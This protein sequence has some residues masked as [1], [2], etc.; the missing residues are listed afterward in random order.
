MRSFRILASIKLAAARSAIAFSVTSIT[1]GSLGWMSRLAEAQT[2]PVAPLIAGPVNEAERVTLSGNVHPLA[3]AKYD[4]GRVEDSFAAGRLYLILKRPNQQEQ[5]LEQFLRDA[6]TAGTASYHQWLTPDAF[7]ARFGPADSDI[8]A[9][10]A[11]L[12]S[13]G[14]TVNKVHPGKMAIEFSGSMA[15]LTAAFHTEIH[16]YGIAGATQYANAS[17]PQIPAAL[18]AVVS[19][20]SP[21]NSFHGQPMIKVQG[22]TNYNKTTHVA[23]PEWTYP[24]GN[25]QEVFELAPADFAVQYDLGPVYA[26]GMTGTGQSIGIL[27]ASNVDLSLV[28][29]YQSLFSLPANLPTVVV[30]GI[31]P[32]Q[33]NAA[34]EAYLD[35]EQA[36]AIAPG[37]KVILYT[38]AGTVLTDPLL[39]SAL[40]AL[41]DNQVSVISMS[42]GVCEAA[43][44]ASGNAAWSALW[45]EAAAQGITG[46]V[47]AGDGGAAGCDNFDTEEFAEAGLA[48]NGYGSTPYNVSVGG[49]DFYF[50]DYAMG[51]SAL[52]AQIWSYWN[53]T[54]SAQPATSLLKPAPEQVWNTSFGL[55][56]NDAGVYNPND[57]SIVS[58]G[59]GAS[60]AAFYPLSG[61]VTGYPKPLWQTGSGVPSDHVRDLPDIALFAGSGSN[62]V[63]YPICASPGDCLNT[64][65]AGA[66]YVTSVGGTSAASPSMAAIQ[67]LVD[68]AT[69]SRQGQAD[70][71]YYAL[72]GKAGAAAAFRDIKVGGNEVP[73]YAGTS[74]CAL[75]TSGSS[76]GWFAESGYSAGVGYDQ[77]SGLGTVDVA[78][79]IQEWTT[80]ALKP[81]TTTLS[82][83][84]ATFAHG[85]KVTMKATVSPESGS[86]TP[87][88]N[89]GLTSN[90]SAA[91][92]NALGVFTLASGGVSSPVDNLPGG[93]YQVMANYSGDGT[94]AAS[95]STPVTVMVSPESDTLN[96]SGWV[97]NPLDNFLYPLVAG[98]S[99]PYGSEVYL[100]A[101]PVGVNEANSTLAQ[102]APATG[103]VTFSDKVGTAT[104]T[105][106][107]ALNSV[108]VAEWT[109]A[110]LAVGGHT[111]S[112]AYP[113]D[114]SYA[115]SSAA[116]AATLTV[117]KGTTT[118]FVDPLETNVTAGSTVTV[119]VEMYSDY[120]PL[121]GTLPTGTVSVTLGSQTVT[122]PWKS[123][124][125]TGSAIEDAV[126]TFSGVPVGILPLTATYAGDANW[127]GTSTL[128]G[129]VTSLASKP[130]PTVT[131][132]A[133]TTSYTPTQTVTMTGTVTGSAGG[134]APTGALNF[135]WEDG[136]QSLVYA[137]QK[138]S[139]NASAVTLT[140]PASEL[141]NGAN[142]FVAT[143]K[144]DANYSAQSSA[145]LTLTLNGG[146]FSLTTTTQEVH[147]QVG[148]A[149]T[150]TVA[151]SPVNGYSGAVAISCS[152]PT[153]ITCSATAA[154]PTVGTGV[155]DTITFNVASTV[156]A[157]TYSAVVTATGGGHT[158]TAQILV[159]CSPSAT[160]PGAVSLKPASLTFPSTTDGTTSTAQTVTVTN[161]GTN[162]VTFSSFNLT[163]ANASAFLLSGKTC[164]TSLTAG[165]SCTLSVAFAPQSA[166]TL[167]ASLAATDNASGSPQ[168]VALSGA[169]TSAASTTATLSLTPASMTFAST[170]VGLTSAAQ[171][172]TVTNTGTTAVSVR[173]YTF[174]GS[175]A[176]D[177]SLTAKTCSTSLAAG[178]S[179]TLTIAFKPIAA[180]AATASLV[181]TDSAS[182]SPQT[183]PLTGTGIPLQTVSLTPS[184]LTFAATNVGTTSVPQTVTIKNTGTTAVTVK[185]YAFTGSNANDFLLPSKTCSTS[186]AAGTSCTLSIT[187]EAAAAGT[188]TASLVATDSANGSPQTISL[189]GTGATPATVSL[190][191]SSLTFAA[192]NVG[193]SSAAQTITMTNTSATAMTVRSFALSGSNAT[194][195]LLAGKTCLTSLAAGASCTLSVAF[196][197]ITAGSATASLAATDSASGS[198][199]TVALTGTGAV[200]GTAIR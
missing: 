67:A 165:A 86:G 124:G 18:A 108:G 40:R 136:S 118:I 28:Q 77:A 89:V 105:G 131:L 198:P 31:D 15:Q 43:L 152:A 83:T 82:I 185:S 177:F 117:F 41:E 112:A 154:S 99:I 160:T 171:T 179:C 11:W 10:T 59:G 39:T 110:S 178:A 173:S 200:T 35:V 93:T 109:P 23:T 47:A 181:A 34:T 147:V 103:A 126:V 7:G 55:N 50:S 196:K 148:Q 73:C 36:G 195:F 127:F 187:F 81:S 137:L 125:T 115:A 87:T 162:A 146:D 155:S 189:T 52:N 167:T 70:Y 174:T 122:A 1:V 133:A 168:T 19:G 2:P 97:L 27:S 33:N 32:G 192:T 56:A 88:G 170:M 16:R 191:P 116:T 144:G 180:G 143:F 175:D 107:A 96:T 78:N 111:I 20:V 158:H 51:A 199:Q 132:T 79:L 176:S 138:V 156:V 85:T 58:G 150:G 190:S 100:D 129:T 141:A 106:S 169:G 22:K 159:G 57:S 4:L 101:Q 92:S 61:P 17:D 145:P 183:V 63:Y 45:Q 62:Y 37:A 26:A 69:K 44:G 114:G 94:Y 142:L 95:V 66:V 134:P 60:N 74:N 65:S 149:G 72:A 135:T 153:G 49:T 24:L 166:G 164:S 6:H 46:F 113:G 91:Y 54:T 197:P 128:Y 104:N 98:M 48:V 80:I 13:Q 64:N 188:A 14:L 139:A 193:A 151:V 163:G 12:E 42:Y 123:W 9:V 21:M 194:D 25:S 172:I 140:F 76:A 119:D 5:A 102:N 71:V 68:Q 29:A 130:A 184:S 182:S 90:D 157:G 121:N 8:A 161:T 38:S 186:L 3:R 120:L 30:D 84:P 75:G 53:E